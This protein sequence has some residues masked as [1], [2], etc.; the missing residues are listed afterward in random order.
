M[1]G[2]VAIVDRAGTIQYLNH[3]APGYSLEDTLGRN[4]CDFIEPGYR[5]IARKCIE[6][7]F[8]TGQADF[9]EAV[10][11]GPN[12]SSSSYET[13]VGPV[14]VGDQVVAVRLVSNDISRRKR[15]EEALIERETRLLEAQE[16]ASLGF[17]VPDIA[18][19]RWTS[20]L[21]LDRIFGI[22]DDYSK[23]LEGWD[24]LVHPDERQAM[25]DYFLKEVVG[26]RRP[27]DREYRIVRYGDKEVRWVHG[28][29]RL[30]FNEDG[31]PVS[32]RSA[33]RPPS[34]ISFTNDGNVEDR[35]SNSTAM[36][37]LGNSCRF[38]RMP[39]TASPR[40]H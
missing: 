5:E 15:A 20:S 18:T 31:Q 24:D 37:S 33:L 34:R 27:F 4:A 23:T 28:L 35:R 17:Y 40:N 9:Y 3:T 26:G 1:P 6:R 8:D 38:W 14:R 30:Q 21:V 7:V 13:Y 2:F 32:M 12:G 19:G 11:A 29:G 10:A 22:P 36:C 16:V 39:F 25:L